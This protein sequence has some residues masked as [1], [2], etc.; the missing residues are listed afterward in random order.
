MSAVDE[1]KSPSFEQGRY[2]Y[3]VVR[4]DGGTEGDES[5]D[6]GG[7]DGEEPY[8]IVEGGVGAVVHACESVYDS[9]DM[10]QIKEWLV[11]HQLVVDAAG[12]AFGTPLPFRFDTILKGDDDAVADWLRESRDDLAGHL[13]DLAGCWEYRIGVVRTGDDEADLADADERLA[14]L[15]EEIDEAGEGRRFLLEKQ[16]DQRLA[17][18]R[19]GRDEDL[20]DDLRERLVP[21]VRELETLGRPSVSME[22]MESPAEDAVVRL[23]ILAEADREDEIGAELDEVAA[24][25]GIE[26][27]FTGPWPPY[28]FAPEVD[29]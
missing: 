6:V 17:E 11:A 23:S 13:D 19:R 28:S 9:D 22:G 26:V 5:L 20:G 1:R 10:R 27:R 14:E 2:L 21:L 7:I 16:Y 4:A 25:P 29:A 18:L 24:L 8:L 15:R 3:C 12:E